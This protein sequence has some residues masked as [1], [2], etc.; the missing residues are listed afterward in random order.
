MTTS[1]TVEELKEKVLVSIFTQYLHFDYSEY[2]RE[3]IHESFEDFS[4]SCTYEVDY[5]YRPASYDFP[6][7]VTILN[8]WIS[9]LEVNFYDDEMECDVEE[10]EDF[11]NLELAELW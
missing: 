7:E 6:S 10:V 3:T 1:I 11:V 9:N 5:K 2:S 8:S 4:I